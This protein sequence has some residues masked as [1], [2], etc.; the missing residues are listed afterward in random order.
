[1]SWDDA[2]RYKQALREIE[3][4]L[5]WTGGSELVWRA[6]YGEIF[7]TRERVLLALRSRLQTT[8]YAQLD[9]LAAEHGGT[10]GAV[11]ALADAHA[12]V[13][14]ALALPDAVD[15]IDEDADA[16]VGAA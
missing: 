6:A 9:D 11:R 8:L 15:W 12:G 10:A 2:H 5:N 3:T 13:V 1:M 4:E 7:G 16:L 14:R